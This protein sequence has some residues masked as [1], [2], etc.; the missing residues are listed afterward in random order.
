MLIRTTDQLYDLIRGRLCA[1]EV[2]RETIVNTK[3][4]HW[5]QTEK[6]W[7]WWRGILVWPYK[8]YQ[9]IP[10]CLKPVKHCRSSNILHAVLQMKKRLLILV[11]F[12]LHVVW[13]KGGEK[14][15]T[16]QTALLTVFSILYLILPLMVCLISHEL[17]TK[18][19]INYPL[20]LRKLLFSSGRRISHAL[21][22]KSS[23][24]TPEIWVATVLSKQ[25][26]TAPTFG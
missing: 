3:G 4:W 17:L 23:P 13:C 14:A 7:T 22:A 2:T 24:E 18:H 25:H 11:V 9:E 8:K 10:V 20:A 1:T 21:P 19:Q 12:Y 5:N 16:E 6:G 26:N 15:R